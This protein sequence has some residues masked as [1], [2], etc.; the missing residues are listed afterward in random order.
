[1]VELLSCAVV[2]GHNAKCTEVKVLKAL[3]FIP[4]KYF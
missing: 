4:K 1:M 3:R 2:G